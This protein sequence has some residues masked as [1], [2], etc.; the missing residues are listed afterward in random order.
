MAE[1]GQLGQGSSTSRPQT[2]TSCQISD[3]IR[4]EIKGKINVICLNHLETI[5]STSIHG[6]IVF[7]EISPWCRKSWGLLIRDELLRKFP[8]LFLN[9]IHG[10][11]SSFKG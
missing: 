9:C 2:G 11:L 7:P 3:G 5:L 6:K 1:H 4:L 10:E 8:S